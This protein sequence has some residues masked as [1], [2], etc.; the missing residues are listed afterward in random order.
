MAKIKNDGSTQCWCGKGETWSPM[1]CWWRYKLV[2][3]LWKTVWPFLNKLNM[4][5]SMQPS[6]YIPGRLS[7]RNEDV[8]SHRNLYT[9][10]HSSFVCNT[11]WKQSRCLPWVNGKTVVHPF[12]GI[13][14][15]DKK[16]WTI[17][18]DVQPSEQLFRE[19]C[20][21]KEAN[22]KWLKTVQFHL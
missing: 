22:A 3:T 14:L 20:W 12:H 7:N 17:D 1:S 10:V 11:L 13:V 15:H 9:S 2:Q 5:L 21:M 18:A 8:R 19:L 6:N 16:E 4:Q